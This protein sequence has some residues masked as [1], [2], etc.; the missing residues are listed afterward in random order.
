[1]KKKIRVLALFLLVALL[2]GCGREPADMSSAEV[3]G[4][5]A[6]I[7]E[8]RV[9]LPFCVVSKSDY[10]AQIGI[11][12]GDSD[13]RVYA[14]SDASTQEWIVNAFRWDGGAMLYKEQSVTE[15]P[16]GLVSEYDGYDGKSES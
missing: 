9:Y 6:I 11:V 13:D 4:Y 2:C 8:E 16:E 3:D 7:W 14:F 5:G 10:G 12:D 1:M 15:I